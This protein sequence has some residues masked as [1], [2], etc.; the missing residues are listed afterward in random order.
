MF[1]AQM[2]STGRQYT[3]TF[4]W[5]AIAG[6]FIPA[7][8]FVARPGY[9]GLSLAALASITC[10]VLAWTGW[11]KSSQLAIPSISELQAGSNE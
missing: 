5:L 8:T 1:D 6:I 4:A 3:T 2:K 10:A 7:M 11:K 9:I